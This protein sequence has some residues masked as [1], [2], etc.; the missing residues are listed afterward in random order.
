M[1]SEIPT[2]VVKPDNSL[3][4][5]STFGQSHLMVQELLQHLHYRRVVYH[6]S[7]HCLLL[8]TDYPKLLLPVPPL[9]KQQ[10]LLWRCARLAQT[11]IIQ[12]PLLSPLAFQ[13]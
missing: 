7:K 4:T 3:L 9:S 13:R 8:P 11:L 10:S 2:L 1:S 6:C 5:G 12:V